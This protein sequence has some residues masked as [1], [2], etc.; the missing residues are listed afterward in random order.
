LDT[1]RADPI[2]EH[3]GGV[4][5]PTPRRE[6]TRVRRLGTL[7]GH[8]LVRQLHLDPYTISIVTAPTRL[9]QGASVVLRTLKDVTISV[10]GTQ[11]AETTAALRVS[12]FLRQN[13]VVLGLEDQLIPPVDTRLADGMTVTVAR[14]VTDTAQADESLPPPTIRQDDPGLTKG[15]EEQI[16]AGIA[17]VRR[18]TYQMTKKDVHEMAR[19]SPRS[20]SRHPTPRVIE[21]GPRCRTR[22]PDRRPCTR[23]RSAATHA[24][25][26]STYRASPLDW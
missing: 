21:A 18:V 4:Q 25:R 16:Q 26:R 3:V 23:A 2:S 20:R 10:D 14:I 8:A 24:R 1:G 22:A 13:S 7:L 9:T 15:Q 11:H 12:E 6:E 5:R 17:G 19:L